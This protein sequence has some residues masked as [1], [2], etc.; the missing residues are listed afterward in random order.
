[1]KL[2]GGLAL[3]S[4]LLA[5]TVS[6]DFVLFDHDERGSAIQTIAKKLRIAEISTSYYTPQHKEFVYE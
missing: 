4:M 3:V 6:V 1:M 2:V 5:I